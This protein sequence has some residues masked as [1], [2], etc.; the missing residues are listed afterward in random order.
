MVE[1]AAVRRYR[2]SL[3][4]SAMSFAL[5][6]MVLALAAALIYLLIRNT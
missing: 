2:E 3:I 4:T 5:L 6:L 1:R